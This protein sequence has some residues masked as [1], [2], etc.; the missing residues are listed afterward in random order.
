MFSH[1]IPRGIRISLR[2]GVGNFVVLA[3][4]LAHGYV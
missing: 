4:A 3:L 2:N 1:L